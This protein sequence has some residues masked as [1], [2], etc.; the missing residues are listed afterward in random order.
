MLLRCALVWALF[1]AGGCV[2]EQVRYAHA[3]ELVTTAEELP[4]AQLLDVAV[5]VLESG[6]PEGEVD[7]EILEELL[8]EQ[9]FTNIRRAESRY[10]AIQIQRTLEASG[11]WGS[12]RA[13]P[14]ESLASDVNIKGKILQSDGD[15]LRLEILASDAS[16]R[17]WIDKTYALETAA[18]AYDTR[19]YPD[20]DPYQDVF[21]QIANDLAAAREQL[22]GDELAEIRTVA[23]LRFAADLSPDAF[24]E[25]LAQDSR[26]YY[27]VQRLPAYGDPMFDRALRVREREYLFVDTLNQ[28]YE[29]FSSDID[30]PYGRWRKFARE[31]AIAVRELNAEKNWRYLVGGLTLAMSIL[32]SDDNRLTERVVSNVGTYAGLEIIK[33]GFARRTEARMHAAT[34]EELSNGFE[35]ELKPL[36]VEMEGNTYRLTGNAQDQYE[37]WQRLLKDLYAAETG[38]LG[39]A[40]FEIEQEP[41][42]TAEELEII[43]P[44]PDEGAVK[45]EEENAN[46]TDGDAVLSPPQQ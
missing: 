14:V 8:K 37:E 15:R 12:V 2:S 45:L 44:E 17:R 27:T 25:H 7:P 40:S 30:D 11:H 21:N 9:I 5:V 22:D 29:N 19:K 33:S 23:Q 6:V 31:E 46:E 28:H 39:D 43:P 10:L 42:S 18:V 13:A 38:F 20:K 1:V 26:G 41:E 36:V 16:G 24:G 4:E 3:V 32:Y 34:L 35:D